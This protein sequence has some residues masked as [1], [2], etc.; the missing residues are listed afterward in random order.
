[1]NYRS[2]R[3]FSGQESLFGQS[4]CPSKR[5]P[6]GPL[7]AGLVALTVRDLAPQWLKDSKFNLAGAHSI[8]L[9]TSPGHNQLAGFRDAPGTANEARKSQAFTPR[10]PP[11]PI[12]RAR[13]QSAARSHHRAQRARFLQ[14]S[15]ERFQALARRAA[16]KS[17]P[18]SSA[19]TRY[20]STTA[21]RPR[22][23]I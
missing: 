9:S 3:R 18:R 8:F 10:R 4:P 23:P 1:M 17:P 21:Q 5:P 20:W 13:R 22:H 11:A 15:R 12:A 19:A 7:D 14:Q 2:T 16:P 6:A